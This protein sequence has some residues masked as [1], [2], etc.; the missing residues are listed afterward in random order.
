MGL[1][2]TAS[3]REAQQRALERGIRS[4]LLS[5][6]GC[7]N[8]SDEAADTYISLSTTTVDQ[9]DMKE[10]EEKPILIV[11]NSVDYRVCVPEVHVGSKYDCPVTSFQFS[12]GCADLMNCTSNVESESGPGSASS[13]SDNTPPNL[14]G[15]ISHLSCDKKVETIS[16]MGSSKVIKKIP[17]CGT[18]INW[19]QDVLNGSG[20]IDE[21]EKKRKRVKSCIG[22]TV[23]VTVADTGVLQGE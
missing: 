9:N 22:G 10:T 12:K 3:S 8:S 7:G 18:S 5:Q 23:E 11:K 15:N 20:R 4:R 1:D 13:S 6:S 16:G 19:V 14:S 17:P 2:P 21:I